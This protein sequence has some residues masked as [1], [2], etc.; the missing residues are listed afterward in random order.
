[1]IRVGDDGL[2]ELLGRVVVVVG[3][4]EI[5]QKSGDYDREQPESWGEGFRTTLCR[6]LIDSRLPM[7]GLADR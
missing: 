3:V 4:S 5:Q 2:S 6:V 7:A 1:M